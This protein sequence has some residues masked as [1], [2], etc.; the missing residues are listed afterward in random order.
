MLLPRERLPRPSVSSVPDVHE[1]SA[2][3]WCAF[4]LVSRATVGRWAC[5]PT[6]VEGT[7][8]VREAMATG[9]RYMALGATGQSS[10][11]P[12]PELATSLVLCEVDPE[13]NLVWLA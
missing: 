2:C 7:T 1:Q 9:A 3:R 4:A 11:I 12:L 8:A 10:I 13:G 6:G 5:K